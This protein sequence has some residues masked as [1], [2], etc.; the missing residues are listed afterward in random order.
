MAER[1]Y[2]VDGSICHAIEDEMKAAEGSE[3]LCGRTAWPDRWLGTENMEQRVKARGLPFCVSC[4]S[5][6]L[7]RG[8]LR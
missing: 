2:V 7:T 4:R 6:V 1:V 5:V 3:A 8:G